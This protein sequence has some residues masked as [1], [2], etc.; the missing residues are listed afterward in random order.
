MYATHETSISPNADNARHRITDHPPQRSDERSAARSAAS[1]VQVTQLVQE[2]K[3]RDREPVSVTIWPECGEAT[4][5]WVGTG[6]GTQLAAEKE[7]AGS[8]GLQRLADQLRHEASQR[9]RAARARARMRRYVI[10]NKLTRMWTLT[11]AD[12]VHDRAV[13]LEAMQE[14]VRRLRDE[15]GEAIPYLYVF[16]WHKLNDRGWHVH[17]LVQARRV[18]HKRMERLWGHGF[19][20]Y[21][22]GQKRRGVSQRERARTAATYA[23]KYVGKDI[24]RGLESGDH[25]YEVAQGFRPERIARSAGTWRAGVALAVAFFGGLVPRV[26]WDS[27]DADVWFGPPVQLLDFGEAA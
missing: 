22:D 8:H 14:F 27:S 7:P 4:V 5:T 21:S 11:F 24:E 6:Q 13:A 15:F 3:R 16:E 18:E 2:P 20:Q 25:A 23:A 10:K 12:E 26:M 17:M 19:V 9:A 1:L